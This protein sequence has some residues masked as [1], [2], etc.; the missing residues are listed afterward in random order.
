MEFAWSCSACCRALGPHGANKFN[1]SFNPEE[2]DHRYRNHP[3]YN[4]SLAQLTSSLHS[5]KPPHQSHLSHPYMYNRSMD[6]YD[7]RPCQTCGS[8]SQS[9][10]YQIPPHSVKTGAKFCPDCGAVMSNSPR[11][12]KNDIPK[13]T[14]R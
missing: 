9:I 13:I 4:Y 7:E 3:K 14:E 10:K 5:V 11:K 12:S 2:Y 8:S 1:G 6:K